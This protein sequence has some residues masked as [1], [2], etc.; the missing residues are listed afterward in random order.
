M[1]IAILTDIHEDIVSLQLGISKA[2]KLQVDRMV[3]LG[4][5]SGFSVPHYQH[6]NTRSAS[7]CLKLLRNH[8]DTF[9]LGNHDLSAIGQVPKISPQFTYPDNWF[10]LDYFE[11]KKVSKNEVWMYE[12]NE[13]IPLYRTSDIVFLSRQKEWDVVE[14]DGIRVLLSHFAYPNLTGSGTG[15]Y[16]HSIDFEEH[17]YFMKEKECTVSVVGHA[18]AT[19]LLW[20]TEHSML[21]N[22]FR[23][24]KLPDTHVCVVAPSVTKGGYK[25]GFLLLDTVNREVEAIR[26]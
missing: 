24:R 10:D 4:D 14:E 25:N 23:R 18:H 16:H 12:E 13:L 2:E 17:F 15:F 5:I 20:F 21:S 7:G 6:H 11:K 22:G 9:I 8:C 3:C 19:G 1:R 26:I